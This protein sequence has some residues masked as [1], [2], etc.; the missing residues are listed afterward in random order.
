[1]A[2]SH[3]PA[4]QAEL[5]RI[6]AKN[7]R[8]HQHLPG[9]SECD[10]LM[11]F[12]S[13]CEVC[14]RTA[15][16]EAMVH[17]PETGTFTCPDCLQKRPGAAEGRLK[18]FMEKQIAVGEILVPVTVNGRKVQEHHHRL[19]DQEVRK[20]SRGLTYSPARASG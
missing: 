14:G 7:V 18:S 9:L 5:N 17:D 12:Y 10:N 13:G 3:L 16:K 1:M 15:H 4:L 19:W 11:N 20:V 2:R 6:D 8:P